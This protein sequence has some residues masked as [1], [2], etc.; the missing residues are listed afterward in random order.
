MSLKEVLLVLILLGR[1]AHSKVKPERRFFN[2]RQ[3]KPLCRR[4]DF[5]LTSI[6]RDGSWVMQQDMSYKFEM[7]SCR[8]KHFSH[9]HAKQCLKG[10]HLLFMGDSLSRYF[11]LSLAQ[12]LA[13]KRWG[14]R[15]SR[16]SH[17]NV[18]QSM[19]VEH[20]F[21]DKNRSWSLFYEY[22]NGILNA[23]RENRELC[24]CFREDN[25]PF[26]NNSGPHQQQS[27][28]E[29]RFY[30][31]SPGGDL[32]DVERDIRL[33]YIQWYGPMPMRG[34]SPLAFL[35]RSRS[36][37]VYLEEMGK[38]F[39]SNSDKT[40]HLDLIPY[41]AHCA[42]QRRANLPWDY[43]S[44]FEKSNCPDD[45]PSH[46][47]QCLSFEKMVVRPMNVTNLV[48]NIGWHSSLWKPEVKTRAF[49]EK[50]YLTAREVLAE[51]PPGSSMPQLLWRGSNAF[52]PFG[53]TN[54]QDV[55]KFMEEKNEP[56]R[57]AYFDVWSLTEPL[58]S[59]NAAIR[60][61]DEPALQAAFVKYRMQTVPRVKPSLSPLANPM[62]DHAHYEPYVYA[63]INNLFLNAVC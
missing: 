34:Y 33:S 5:N 47:G 38:M 39:C 40:S 48:A 7:S 56:D 43:P 11:Y 57:M 45:F 13:T 50:L 18:G 54:D 46:E 6:H 23:D 21:K 8:V 49:L 35:P 55:S 15:F 52:A 44:F 24:D 36:Y 59:I 42:H 27:C 12:L 60:A 9:S 51:R 14:Q 2:E 58:A 61:Q 28:F 19:L 63:E 10:H 62:V 3:T 16:S 31:H 37:S 1:I 25:L 4:S 53:K 41:S 20:D 17:P 30:R 22:S 32:D 29:N 26:Y